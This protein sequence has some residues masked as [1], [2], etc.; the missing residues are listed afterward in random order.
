VVTM[1]VVR[2]WQFWG[3]WVKRDWCGTYFTLG[4]ATYRSGRSFW[5]SRLWWFGRVVWDG[6][7][8]W[9]PRGL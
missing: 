1:K 2:W 7:H 8:G 5:T 6:T 3:F 4:P 9:R